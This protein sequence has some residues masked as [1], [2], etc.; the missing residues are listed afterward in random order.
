M[1]YE[2]TISVFYPLQRGRLVLRTDADWNHEIEPVEIDGGAHRFDFK[3]A[4]GRPYFYF[5]PCIVEGEACHWSRGTNYLA[6]PPDGGM[7]IYPHFF[8]DLEGFISE[9]IRVPAPRGDRAHH[10]RVYYP[11]GYG[12]NHLKRYPVLYMHDG[13]NLFFPEEAFFGYE[14]QIDETMNL[15][16]AMNLIDKTIVVGIWSGAR[17][18]DYTKPGYEAYGRYIVEGLKPYVDG[19][20]RTLREARHT[21][22]LGS[23][24]GGVVSFFLGWEWP[25]VFGMVG[26]LSS[27]FGWRDDLMARVEAEEKRAITIYLDS[28]W[29]GDNYEET[30]TM[31][32]ILLRKGYESGCE[33]FY[34]A[35]PEALHNEQ[36]WAMRCHIPL[37]FLFGKMPRLGVPNSA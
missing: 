37:Q 1:S 23:S 35:F 33:L 19:R 6:I 16:D 18:E 29:P 22:V 36:Y 25:E 12:E 24:L 28:G 21:A 17:E 5:K 20:F 14:W 2:I 31:R 4:T 3:I 11:P 10:I 7:E 15:L 34:L 8:D 32:N 26:C 13:K 27:T 30:R 9:P